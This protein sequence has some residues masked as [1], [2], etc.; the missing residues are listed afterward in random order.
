[1]YSRD[2][3]L[4]PGKGFRL[5]RRF[6]PGSFSFWLVLAAIGFAIFDFVAR[7]PF[8][9]AATLL[10]ALAFLA[11]SWFVSWSVDGRVLVHRALTLRG[12]REERLPAAQI[13]GV[14][15]AFEKERARAFIE[16]LEGEEV[17]L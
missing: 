13:R 16:T 9:G 2:F 14:H 6:S 4:A 7:R 10:L 15:V 1:M 12:L 8:V 11:E 17:P 3:E 5:R